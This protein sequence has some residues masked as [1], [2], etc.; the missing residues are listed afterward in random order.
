[1]YVGSNDVNPLVDGRGGREGKSTSAGPDARGGFACPGGTYAEKSAL[2]VCYL[3]A[4]LHAVGN[5]DTSPDFRG[6]EMR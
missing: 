1:M 3:V 4:L 2:Q 5:S 6:P